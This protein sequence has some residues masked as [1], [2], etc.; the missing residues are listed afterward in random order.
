[1]VMKMNELKHRA[2]TQISFTRNIEEGGTTRKSTNCM[3]PF[4]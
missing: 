4:I 1:M 3:I 2:T